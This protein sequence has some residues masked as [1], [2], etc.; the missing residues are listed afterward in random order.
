ME[1]QTFYV[2]EWKTA[3]GSHFEEYTVLGFLKNPDQYQLHNRKDPKV[4]KSYSKQPFYE[5][6]HY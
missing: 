4:N 6:L 2:K 5:I 1:E 3:K